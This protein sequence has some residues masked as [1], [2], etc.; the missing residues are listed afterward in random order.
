MT[1]AVKDR[2]IADPNDLRVSQYAKRELT[3]MDVA[4]IR[5]LMGIHPSRPIPAD[6]E[7]SMLAQQAIQHRTFSGPLTEES[8]AVALDNAGWEQVGNF[9]RQKIAQK[10]AELPTEEEINRSD[11]NSPD[12]NPE[13]DIPEGELN[14]IVDIRGVN[15]SEVAEILAPPATE[16]KFDPRAEWEGVESG[17]PVLVKT[18]EGLRSGRFLGLGQ[19]NKL[20]IKVGGSEKPYQFFTPDLVRKQDAIPE[21]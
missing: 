19:V 6:I 8:I 3:T 11:N 4:N 20:R 18:D 9:V 16:V 14:E 13:D 7:L 2:R 21:D 5:A 17:T 10:A 15:K 12:Y 1:Q